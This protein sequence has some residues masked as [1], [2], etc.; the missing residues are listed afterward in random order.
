[1]SLYS[2]EK[3]VLSGPYGKSLTGRKIFRRRASKRSLPM[4]PE[5]RL[6]AGFIEY[7]RLVA[8]QCIV[9]AIYNQ[10]NRGP[11]GQQIAVKMGLMP[12]LHDLCLLAKFD[13]RWEPHFIEVKMPSGSFTDEQ[14]GV[15]AEFCLQ[16][17]K[18]ATVRSIEELRVALDFWKIERREVDCEDSLTN[19]EKD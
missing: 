7:L 19:C 10:G 6:Q 1:M 16:G 5:E 14:E 3:G 4:K 2:W 9:F 8:P 15:H 18:Q 13:G 17:I 11:V 12:G